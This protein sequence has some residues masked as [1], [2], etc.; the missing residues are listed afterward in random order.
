MSNPGII[1]LATK[2]MPSGKDFRIEDNIGEA[3]HIHYGDLRLDLSISE[4]KGVVQE[5]IVILNDLLQ[6]TGLKVDELDPVFLDMI[7][8]KLI[9]LETVKYDKIQ[10]SDIKIQR[11]NKIG[12]PVVR[13]L[14]QS[15]M[16][17][18]LEGKGREYHYFQQENNFNQSNEERLQMI[19]KS[20]KENGYPY[21][22]KYLIFF[23]E[24]NNI[25]DGQHRAASMLEEFEE[26]TEIEIKRLFFRNN[27]YNESQHP[28]MRY[29]FIWNGARIK[30][31]IRYLV[32]RIK[33]FLGR[34]KSKIGRIVN[35]LI[36][37]R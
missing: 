16:Y 22:G 24:Q 5:S 28:W 1:T 14:R 8:D 26:N 34:I 35:K 20:I 25:R 4:F 29:L 37:E 18:A 30:S 12:L 3:I 2:K 31:L 13:P 10:I 36:W 19:H 11:K 21:D 15:C 27:L 32:H 9:D 23:N 6:N 33:Y 17:K 7:S